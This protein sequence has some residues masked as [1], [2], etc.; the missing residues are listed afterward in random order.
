[1]TQSWSLRWRTHSL[2]G[3]LGNIF[4]A[5]QMGDEQGVC[6]RLALGLGAW[7]CE[8]ACSGVAAVTS[9]PS[10]ETLLTQEGRQRQK[11]PA[12]CECH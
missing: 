5:H 8:D 7:L 6:S 1:M 2:E 12:S 4:L 10:V 9:R 11:G 3:F